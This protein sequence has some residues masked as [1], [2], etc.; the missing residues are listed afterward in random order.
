M[1]S[2]LA[3]ILLQLVANIVVLQLAVAYIPGVSFSGT[4]LDIIKAAGILTLLNIVLKPFVEFILAPF[5]FLTLGL[6]SL[7]INAAML[8][9]ATY[10]APQLTFANWKALLLT[11]VAFAFINFLFHAAQA[12]N[13]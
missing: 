4:L 2:F 11:A 5:A 10:W 1:P 6:F 12:K 9:L 7:I 8:W 3:K 13:D